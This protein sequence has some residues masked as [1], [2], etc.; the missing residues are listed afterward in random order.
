MRTATPITI[1][2]IVGA[3]VDFVMTSGPDVVLDVVFGRLS[4]LEGVM[5]VDVE[6]EEDV[7][8]EEKDVM[9]AELVEITVEDVDERI[10]VELGL[11]GGSMLHLTIVAD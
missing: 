2:A 3:E 5:V 9:G 1:P 7:E 11:L 4:E 8:R 6:E 10:V